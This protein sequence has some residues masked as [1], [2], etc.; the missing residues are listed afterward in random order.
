MDQ[1][2]SQQW[3]EIPLL[4][5]SREEL[6]IG[7]V[8]TKPDTDTDPPSG[9]EGLVDRVFGMVEQQVTAFDPPREIAICERGRWL[10]ADV[11]FLLEES[12]GGT[13]LRSYEKRAW[14]NVAALFVEVPNAVGL[15]DR[16]HRKGHRGDLEKLKM[17]AEAAASRGPAE[18][19]TS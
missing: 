10:V 14:K 4:M 11:R 6:R 15:G 17:L 1:G 16:W 2:K 3:H 8:A 5:A 9:A 13:L 12:K 7:H 19:G 18:V